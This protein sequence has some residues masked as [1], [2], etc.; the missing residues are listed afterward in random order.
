MATECKNLIRESNVIGVVPFINKN[1]PS[2]LNKKWSA[3]PAG[4]RRLINEGFTIVKGVTKDETWEPAFYGFDIKIDV[5]LEDLDNAI[6]SE[7]SLQTRM[8]IAGLAS[9]WTNDFINGDRITNSRSMIG[10]K[11]VV[12]SYQASKMAINVGPSLDVTATT[13]NTEKFINAL[14]KASKFVRGTGGKGKTYIFCN[15][16]TE[17]GISAALRH[18]GLLDTTKDAFDRLFTTFAGFAIIDVGLQ[19]DQAT[20]IIPLTETDGG[21]TAETSIYVVRFDEND[22]LIGLQKGKGLKVYDPLGGTEM[23]GQPAHLLRCDWGT[24]LVP[25]SD[26]CVARV[27]GIKNPANWTVPV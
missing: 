22:G 10:L 4:G 26:F 18:S 12:T 2:V 27:Y 3:L 13:S 8:A 24:A 17:L 1:V 20:E 19:S 25:R 21:G 7:T 16:N 6:E 11:K 5:Q 14:H 15:E 23:E 9:D